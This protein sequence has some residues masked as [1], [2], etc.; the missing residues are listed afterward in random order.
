MEDSIDKQTYDF[1]ILLNSDRI[2]DG[3]DP[4]KVFLFNESVAAGLGFKM[5]KYYLGDMRDFYGH[6]F[7]YSFM[8]FYLNHKEYGY[9]WLVEW[10][11]YCNGSWNDVFS[12]VDAFD[13][14]TDF[15]STH[16]EIG[17]GEWQKKWL[18]HV[19]YKWLKSFTPTPDDLVKCFNPIDRFSNKA[20]EVLCRSYLKDGDYGFYE[21]AMPTLF[22]HHGISMKNFGSIANSP[23]LDADIVFKQEFRHK[24]ISLMK[25]VHVYHPVKSDPKTFKEVLVNI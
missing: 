18:P 21:L 14:K 1:F 2:P 6:N 10:D 5:H 16:I 13:S 24:C 20:L 17:P 9:Y 3:V 7:E 12:R 11:V 15:L 8:T 23:I 22:K 19:N 4:S 25:K